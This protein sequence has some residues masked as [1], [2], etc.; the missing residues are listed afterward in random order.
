M[1]LL[2]PDYTAQ[3]LHEIN[4]DI[5]RQNGIHGIILDLDNTIIPWDSPG[6]QPEIVHWVKELLQ[7]NYRICLLSNNMTQ[8]VKHIADS[9]G[10]PYVPRACKPF[11]TGFRQAIAVLQ[12][13]PSEVAVVG[14]QLFTDV[15]G[16]NRLGLF[17]I[18][19]A[20]L[21]TNEFIGTKLTRKIEKLTVCL[22]KVR[23][24]LK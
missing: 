7:K 22:L 21:S 24:L 12:L 11:K 10:V 8:R 1:K 18:W 13:A 6:M 9:L 5:L 3:S 16:G 20:P 17:T 2:R 23:G 4:P 14:D 19:V 15:L